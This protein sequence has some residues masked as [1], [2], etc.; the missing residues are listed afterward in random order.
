MVGDQFVAEELKK[1]KKRNFV[2][3]LVL[4]VFLFIAMGACAVFYYQFQR[5]LTLIRI[6]QQEQE[7]K[8]IETNQFLLS[9]IDW[10]AKRTQMILFM[11]DQ[12]VAEWKRIGYRSGKDIAYV[13]AETNV[14]VCQ[15]YDYIDPLIVLAMQNVESSFRRRI[16]SSAGAV[17]LNQLMPATGR[18]LC[19]YYGIEYR[20]TLLTNI[21]ISTRLA[22]KYM[23]VLFSQY[24]SWPVMLAAY[25][26]GPYQAHFYMKKKDRLV[27]ETAT[28]VPL[29]MSKYE[30][31]KKAFN[32][33]RV[34][35]RMVH[36]REDSG[37]E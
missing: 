30:E 28:Y 8:Q 23:D 7:T 12:I 32:R 37:K 19:G 35:Q 3:I 34:D 31:Y 15:N 20:D 11:R 36:K 13:I 21:Q 26:G 6:S 33:Y 29:V 22:V 25:N 17:G 1:H 9:T 2:N 16:V 18:L 10:S 27:E 14:E 5:E 4:F 24:E